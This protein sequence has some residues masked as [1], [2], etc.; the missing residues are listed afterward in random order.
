MTTWALQDAKNR[1]SEVVRKALS[2]GEQEIC[3]R[4]QPAVTIIATEELKQLRQQH[5]N[6]ADFL[7]NSPLQGLD[8][9]ER[10]QDMG[11][12]IDL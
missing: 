7:L 3:V 10:E 12:E 8:I 6:L 4:G 5:T 9:P 2:E 11:R 1:F